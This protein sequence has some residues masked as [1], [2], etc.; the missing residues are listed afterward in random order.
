MTG[1]GPS[2]R[3]WFFTQGAGFYCH[4]PLARRLKWARTHLGP[5][6]GWFMAERVRG[7]VPLLVGFTPVAAVAEGSHVRLTFTR[8][9]RSR[10]D[11]TADHVIAATGYRPD[12]DRLT[13]L[14]PALRRQ[15]AV[16]EHTPVLSSDFE[17]SVPGLY[18][19]G[20]VAVNSFGPLMRFAVGAK[21][22]APRVA[23]HLAASQGRRTARPTAAD[24]AAALPKD[25]PARV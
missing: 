23:Q 21:F 11:L 3:S 16:E 19:V 1:I 22:A 24:P 17:A 8:G 14:E 4:L 6:G 15:L 9:D 18:F 10:E 20:P 13:M 5:A 12:L 2:W 25:L 7:R